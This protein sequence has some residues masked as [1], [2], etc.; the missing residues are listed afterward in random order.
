MPEATKRQTLEQKR[1]DYAWEKIEEINQ[2]DEKTRKKYGSI[3]RK[4][5]ILVLTNG[6]GPTLAYLLGKDEAHQFLYNH[7]QS[8][9]FPTQTPVEGDKTLIKYI[10]KCS[11]AEYRRLTMEALA[12]LNWIKRFAEATLPTEEG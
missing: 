4:A 7:V 9:I 11:S 5:P 10:G 3:A 12:I 2:M 1:A 6:L 8:W